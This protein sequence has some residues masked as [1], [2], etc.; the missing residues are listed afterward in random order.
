MIGFIFALVV[1]GFLGVLFGM[2][3]MDAAWRKT[4]PR[5]QFHD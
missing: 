5:D 3:W 2:L 1:V 4:G